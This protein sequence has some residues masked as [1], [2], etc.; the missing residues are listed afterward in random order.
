M[1]GQAPITEQ[2][3]HIQLANGVLALLRGLQKVEHDVFRGSETLTALL[4]EWISRTELEMQA[5]EQMLASICD[6]MKDLA[7]EEMEDCLEGFIE[8]VGPLIIILERNSLL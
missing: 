3:R 6:L 7:F 2:E 1:K 4:L 8:D 5:M